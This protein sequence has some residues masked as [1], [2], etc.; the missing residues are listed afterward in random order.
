MILESWLVIQA[1]KLVVAP[2][3]DE[4]RAAFVKDIGQR[5]GGAS[6]QIV[7]GWV[8]RLGKDAGADE[9]DRVRAEMDAQPEVQ[10]ALRSGLEDKLGVRLDPSR[11]GQPRATDAVIVDAYEA[12]FWRIGTLALWERAPIAIEG[13]LQGTE[14]ITVC[15]PDADVRFGTIFAEAHGPLEPS[16][17]WQRSDILAL[18]RRDD[19]RVDFF[20]RRYENATE[21]GTACQ[22]LNR[23]FRRDRETGFSATRE[24]PIDERW[25]RIDAVYATWVR[26]EP[27]SSA[28]VH[29][30]RGRDGGYA[31]MSVDPPKFKE[32]PDEWPPLMD[33][34]DEAAGVAA[35]TAGAD[36]FA[37]GN[38]ALR[39]KVQSLLTGS[40]A[41]N[42]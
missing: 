23:S 12:I 10:S 18:E 36:A 20:V 29:I 34:P 5:V 31:T 38:A 30:S 8:D 42:T 35:L 15:N 7:T 21:R 25:H 9:I 13:A 24:G 14:W 16:G 26:L 11:P 27:D 28:V 1:V 40:G 32:Y 3:A 4:A 6:A 19:P 41:T 39:T 33:I 22:Q 37:S 2:L 17:V